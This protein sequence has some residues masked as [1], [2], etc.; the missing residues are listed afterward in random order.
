MPSSFDA[1]KKKEKKVPQ[2][3]LIRYYKFYRHNGAS[4]SA[5]I[6]S[7]LF[8]GIMWIFLRME[9]PFWR[10]IAR[11]QRLLFPHINPRCPKVFDPLRYL[12]Q[13]IWLICHYL[14][15]L[16][17]KK[18]TQFISYVRNLY[19][20]LF[21]HV[22]PIAIELIEHK[23]KNTSIWQYLL[24]SAIAVLA[25]FFILLSITQPFD[26]TFQF[27]F[28]IV[29]WLVA[30]ALR[31]IHGRFAS[32]AIIMLA[33][34]IA[35]RYIWWRYQSTLYWVDNISLFFGLLLLLA[36][37]YAWCV[38]FLSFMQC[39]W[40]LHRKP[41]SMPEDITK[42]QSVDIFIPTY[43]EDLQI[44]KPTIYASL[45]L[46]WPKDKLTIYLLDDGDRPE[47]KAFAQEVG[48]RYIAREKHN[49][50]KAGNINHALSLAS[51]EFVAIFDCDHI[52]T[53]SFLQFTMGW[54][55]Q[56][57]KMALVQTPHHFFS[58][59]PFERNLGN[60][61]ETP[62]E[63]TL[64]YG[65]VQDGN[66]TWNATFFCGS[67]AVLRRTALDEIGGIAV[68]TVTED[69]HTSLRLHR[70]GW[71]SAYIRIPQ[72]AGLATESLSAHIGQRI[73]WAKGMVQIFRLDN[74]LFGKGL[75]IPQR[76]CYLNAMLHFFSG[77]PR[78]IFLLAPLTFLIFHAYI[79]YAP[80]IAIALYVVPYLIHI[81]LAS[82]KLQ[83][84]YRHSFWGEIYETIL[85][86]YTTRPV[87]STLFSPY[88]GKFNV[89]EKGGVMEEGFV[90]WNI[91]RPYLLFFNLNLLGILFAFWRI[92][93]GDP[94]EA[95]A[96]V[97]CL[98]WVCYN[99]ILLGV[100]IAVSV[101]TKQQR[102]FPRVRIKAPAMLLLNNG[103]LYRCYLYDFSDNSCAI[104]LPDNVILSLSQN[105]NIT[106]L[107]TQNQR[108]H[109]FK[110]NISRIEGQII[111]LQLL[112]MTTQKA[113]D[114]TACT[115][116]RA[117]TWADWQNELPA[118]KPLSSLKNI[119]FI[120]M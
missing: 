91:N 26:L 7:E 50:A 76:L 81:S 96:T 48:I 54:F 82:S 120:S 30:L 111:G 34:T 75:S 108:E 57:E 42:W 113:I 29:L 90:D 4:R 33:L 116:E 109:A 28:V 12:L 110:A 64:F 93:T 98:L 3:I 119:I 100:A 88:K 115:F 31:D 11:K 32:I 55:L 71:R 65:L 20:K 9:S 117:D 18:P 105:E 51:G 78:M 2:H 118:D 14:V 83:G 67:C 66:D 97:M 103:A 27:V 89:T 1:T 52:P 10:K 8:M 36:E 16:L 102:R 17:V 63:G 58:P 46:D 35:C 61:R 85:A 21:V 94:D 13:S 22:S 47:F 43:N 23:K 45:N 56:D 99:L 60:F 107:L 53:R 6:V 41:I 79:I 49:F 19:K 15:Q 25:V 106:L 86:W 5:T 95:W 112:E 72:A 24:Y 84:A 73:R 101:E 44:V 77:I 37:T 68:E 59:D 39:I 87:L 80:A 92:A 69:A 62:N 114:F 38:L 70:H 40:P 74:P 104:L